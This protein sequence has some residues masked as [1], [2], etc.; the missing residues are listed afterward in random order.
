MHLF[1]LQHIVKGK[2]CEAKAF[3]TMKIKVGRIIKLNLHNT[4]TEVTRHGNKKALT[5]SP[6]KILHKMW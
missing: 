2:Q 6:E 1:I 3:P 5:L 4:L